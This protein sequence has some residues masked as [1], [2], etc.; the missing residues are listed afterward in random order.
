[1]YGEFVIS[2]QKNYTPRQTN[3]GYGLVRCILRERG[4]DSFPRQ[5]PFP[6]A[7]DRTQ[8][9]ASIPHPGLK[10]GAMF[11]PPRWGLSYP[12]TDIIRPD[13]QITGTDMYGDVRRVC[14]IPAQILY[15]Q[16]NKLRVRI[17]TDMYRYVRI[18]MG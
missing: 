4:L 14:Y 17:C 15:A 5:T 12:G 10:P 13:K 6:H 7:P 8:S 1:M 9:V 18:C 16:T 2:R 3:Y 11:I